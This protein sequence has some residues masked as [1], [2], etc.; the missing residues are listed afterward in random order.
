MPKSIHTIICVFFLSVT[1]ITDAKPKH[2]SGLPADH[3]H[4]ISPQTF[5][6]IDQGIT[7]QSNSKNWQLPVQKRSQHANGDV[8]L[9]HVDDN[10]RVSLTMSKKGMFGYFS[11]AEGDFLVTTD[12]TG[13]WAIKLPRGQLQINSCGM[14]HHPA[15]PHSHKNLSSTINGLASNNTAANSG[16]NIDL[17]DVLVIYDQALADRYPGELLDTRINQYVNESNQ[18]LTN[19]EVSLRVRLVG[20][21]QVG[22]NFNNSNFETRN[23]IADTLAGTSITGLENVPQLRQD[24][25]ADLVIMVRPHDIET[26]GSCGIAF[27]PVI[28]DNGNYDSSFGVNMVSDG[29]SSWSVCTDQVFVHEIGHNMGAGH[30]YGRGGGFFSPEGAALAIVG[31]MN[32]VMGSF[33]SGFPD[34]FFEVQSFSNPDILCGGRSCGVTGGAEPANNAAVIRQT[35]PF[36]TAYQPE[37]SNAPMPQFSANDPDSDG[38]G[39]SDRND[40]FPFIATETNDT[41]GDGVGDNADAFPNNAAETTDTDGDGQGNNGDTDDDN[42]GV[43]DFS[44]A[45]PLDASESA[46]NDLDGIGNQADAFAD[47][48][49]EQNDFDNDGTGDNADT[50]DDNDGFIDLADTPMDILVISTGNNRILRFDAT[51]G[52]PRGIEVVPSD[53]LLTFQSNLAYRAEDQTLFYTSQSAIKRMNL[54]RR[55][56]EG[57]WVP[58]YDTVN[59]SNLQLGSGFPTAIAPFDNGGKLAVST[60]NNPV[61]FSFK[62]Q[63]KPDTDDVFWEF[64]NVSGFIDMIPYENSILALDQIRRINRIFPDGTA[65]RVGP[66]INSWLSDPYA[67]AVDGDRLFISDQVRNT[68]GVLNITSGE[69][70]G[71]LLDLDDIDYS[72]PGGLAIMGDVLLVAAKDNDAILKFNKNTGAFIGELTRGDGLSQPQHMV[73]VPQLNDRYHNN[74]ERQIRPNAGLWFDPASGGRGLDI[75]VFNNR[76]TAVWYTYD[77]NGLP[78]WY[79]SS[80]VLDGFDYSADFIKITRQSDGNTNLQ[81]VGSLQLRFLS[82]RSAEYSWEINGFSGNEDLMWFEFNRD[83]ATEDYTGLWGPEDGQG[84]GMTLTTQGN[85]TI[86]LPFI[87]D[88]QGEPRWV[89]SEAAT[90]SSPLSFQV[91]AIFS[92]TLCPQCTGEPSFNLVPAGTLELQLNGDFRWSSQI[93]LPA[94]LS[95]TWTLDQ[96]PIQLFSEMQD[97]PR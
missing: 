11:N 48:A 52:T 41:D 33:G 92:D 7:L 43:N 96:T 75:Q 9:N 89:M 34:R 8:S 12:D 27:F 30:Q 13:S 93:T 56:A 74:A 15:Q 68:V 25:G 47:D 54:M 19:T 60:I 69:F 28:D 6:N 71:L 87:Y 57:I 46:D 90:G 45:F 77:E 16:E 50:D 59:F 61:I 84:A 81:T 44:D 31:R 80:D 35:T 23:A 4:A 88:A 53:G 63:Q 5:T 40:V 24:T 3:Y 55:E 95:G 66:V 70:E 18:V 37:V 62:G 22:Y 82:E 79:Y 51:D 38:D 64:E 49:S 58:A 32:T 72:S 85:Q 29:M 36:V 1:Q 65:T 42:D 83:A 76:L 73:L 21:E 17:L 39:V 26:R 67:M 97:R 14:D 20:L 10:A 86:A 2:F 78:I 91:N 94:P